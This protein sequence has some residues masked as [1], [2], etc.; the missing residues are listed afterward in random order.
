MLECLMKLGENWMKKMFK[1]L[2]VV[3]IVFNLF[4][5]RVVYADANTDDK[6]IE[7]QNN[8]MEKYLNLE[9]KYNALKGE[10]AD[11]KIQLE[12]KK[13]KVD[14]NMVEII[15]IIS[16]IILLGGVVGPI[17]IKKYIRH[18]VSETVDKRVRSEVKKIVE[19]YEKEVQIKKNKRLCIIAFQKDDNKMIAP[20][21][22]RFRN[23][24]YVYVNND[25]KDHINKLP[26]DSKKSRKID[27][28][29]FN[30]IN[31]NFDNLDEARVKDI[32]GSV[33]KIKSKNDYL[34]YLGLKKGRFDLG[35]YGV[36]VENVNYA[37]SEITL[38]ANL[39]NAL[40]YQDDVLLNKW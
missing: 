15:T 10:W 26:S 9:S 29:I 35:Q 17:G 16:G 20:I 40:K 24:E 3:F 37:N 6:I 28:V 39:M 19:N 11:E 5:G 4:C 12:D 38:Y 8:I 34:V 25:D 21:L 14:L 31:N 33:E 23:K 36:G 1:Y 30:N 13:R 2:A 22:E 18:R 32:K 7:N 27:A